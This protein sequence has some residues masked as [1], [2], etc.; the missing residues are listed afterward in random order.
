MKTIILVLM[1][2]LLWGCKTYT[3]NIYWE[4]SNPST[5]SGFKLY[6]GKFSNKYIYV[7]DLGKK[8]PTS[9][10][11]TTGLYTHTQ[12]I[13]DRYYKEIRYC[14]MSAYNASGAEGPL[15]NETSVTAEAGVLRIALN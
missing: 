6:C 15:S 14:A 7:I 12:P 5:A 4:Y 2:V 1:L 9:Y 10:N 8:T 3:A 11:G 13:N